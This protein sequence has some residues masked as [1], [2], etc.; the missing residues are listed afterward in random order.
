MRKHILLFFGIYQIL[1]SSCEKTGKD[2]DE[3]N[4]LP[5]VVEGKVYDYGDTEGKPMEST[6]QKIGLYVVQAG[7]NEIINDYSNLSFSSTGGNKDAYFNPDDYNKI[8][9]IDQ[10]SEDKWDVIAYYP[11]DEEL[12]EK[13]NTFHIKVKPQSELP[14]TPIV[15]GKS[16]NIGKDNNHAV[17]QFQPI[18][19]RVLF[20]FK[21]G[22]GVSAGDIETVSVKLGGCYLNGSFKL[23]DGNFMIEDNNKGEIDLTIVSE[24][25]EN[26]NDDIVC[27]HEAI[28]LPQSVDENSIVSI[29]IPQQGNVVRT[30]KLMDDLSALKSGVQYTFNVTVGLKGISVECSSSPIL[31]WGGGDKIIDCEEVNE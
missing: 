24:E 26:T 3:V 12:N 30:Y 5:L 9:F 23:P 11:Y 31:S 22:E 4:K 16:F 14:K 7:K 27:S 29:S 18:L 15:F 19:S 21:P 2:E 20:C 13:E 1:M 8:P 25:S 10:Y 6:S 17:I 28:V